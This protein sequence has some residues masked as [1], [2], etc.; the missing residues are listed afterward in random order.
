MLRRFRSCFLIS[1]FSCNTLI[2][3]RSSILGVI[4]SRLVLRYMHFVIVTSAIYLW[5]NFCHDPHFIRRSDYYRRYLSSV[6]VSDSPFPIS[7]RNLPT[8]LP[9]ETCKSK[10]RNI[11]GLLTL[12]GKGQQMRLSGWS[13]A[14]TSSS[15]FSRTTHPQNLRSSANLLPLTRSITCTFHRAVGCLVTWPR[16]MWLNSA[17]VY[18]LLNISTIGHRLP[19]WDQLSN[20][21]SL[22]WRVRVLFLS[23][24][25][26]L[27]VICWVWLQDI[28]P[29][30]PQCPR[31]P[32][33]HRLLHSLED[34]LTTGTRRTP[35]QTQKIVM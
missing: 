23:L 1:H 30:H 17:L 12:L 24:N 25:N 5:H 26:I 29:I 8:Y 3:T 35:H 7:P 28:P 27:D 16:F 33:D 11:T 14:L 4:D 34:D 31:A 10:N 21:N 22:R 9:T 2:P 15:F 19:C 18:F 20:L 13:S 32:L 6:F